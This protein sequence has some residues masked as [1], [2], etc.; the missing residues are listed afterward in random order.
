MKEDTDGLP[1]LEASA[2][3]LGVRPAIDVPAEQASEVVRPGQG[4]VSVS[5]D[6]PLNLPKH[7][8]PPELQGNGRDPVWTIADS[9]LP[10]DLRFRVDPESPKHG[11]LEPARQMTLLEYEIAINTTRKLWRKLPTS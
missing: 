6:D 10:P 5:P 2:R 4:G 7:R 8:R 11:F 1:V 3:G 9:D